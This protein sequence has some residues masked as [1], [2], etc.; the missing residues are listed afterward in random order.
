MIHL[1]SLPLSDSRTATANPRY[2][3]NPSQPIA[4]HRLH[5]HP[6]PQQVSS[7]YAFVVLNY[8]ALLKILKKHD[9]VSGAQQR[10]VRGIVHER[11]F[12]QAHVIRVTYV[13]HVPHVFTSHPHRSHRSPQA[14]Y[15]SPLTHTP[16]RSPAHLTAHPHTSPQAFYLSLEHSF[17]FEEVGR[18]I[19][20]Q[21]LPDQPLHAS[22]FASPLASPL[23]ARELMPQCSPRTPTRESAPDAATVLAPAAAAWSPLNTLPKLA[24]PPAAAPAARSSGGSWARNFSDERN[25]P[26]HIFDRRSSREISR[27][28]ARESAGGVTFLGEGLGEAAGETIEVPAHFELCLL[29]G[30]ASRDLDFTSLR[31]LSDDRSSGRNVEVRDRSRRGNRGSHTHRR[32]SGG[33]SGDRP[34]LTCHVEGTCCA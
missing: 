3:R 25:L 23:A 2:H 13:P 20:R 7:L 28:S 34:Y 31:N 21:P 6:P 24:S 33:R 30:A 16:H 15:L 27:D 19:Q 29:H 22:P 8:L 11:I 32:D 5:N 10:S 9:K 26:T 17:L 18:L 4:T 14:F 1:V 12:E